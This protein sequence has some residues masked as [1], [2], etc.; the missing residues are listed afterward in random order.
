[1]ATHRFQFEEHLS[2]L[3][4]EII[5]MGARVEK[6]IELS[7]RSL[8]K[9]DVTL[10][11]MVISHDSEINALED[12][13]DDM[14]SKLI[15]TQQPVAKDLRR[16]L[17][18]FKIAN[19]LERMADLAV[20][21]AKAAVRLGDNNVIKPVMDIPRMAELAQQMTNESIIAF[22]EENM[23]QA[24]KMAKMDDEVDHLHSENMLHL[25]THIANDP[26]SINK[27]ILVAFVS[28]YLERIADHA[29]NIG[30]SVV[31]LVRGKKPDLNQ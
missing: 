14:G 19:D 7:V 11:H 13:I 20:D 9:G 24:Y 1:M 29:T 8:V 18:A 22:T 30:E 4:A 28:R 15:A 17:I 25:F 21:I 6:A 2:E 27:A 23:D 31:Y 3:R 5:D 12:K 10:A 16:I 26:Q